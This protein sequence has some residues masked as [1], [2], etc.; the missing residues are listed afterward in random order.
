MAN[1]K[2][3]LTLTIFLGILIFL[4][5]SGVL[6]SSQLS[7]NSQEQLNNQTIDS[8][9]NQSSGEQNC[10]QGEI[11]EEIEGISKC[12][13]YLYVNSSNQSNISPQLLEKLINLLSPYE[14]KP[15]CN[16]HRVAPPQ[17]NNH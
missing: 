9:P 11:L 17:I 2:F 4:F 5:F 16:S 14:R 8:V 6:S 7:V 12:C 3:R 1:N 13:A 10:S 15:I